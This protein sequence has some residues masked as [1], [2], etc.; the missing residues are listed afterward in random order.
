[1]R[2]RPSTILAPLLGLLLGLLATACGGGGAEVVDNTPP[3]PAPVVNVAPN[4]TAVGTTPVVEGAAVILLGVAVDADGDVLMTTWTVASQPAGAAAVIDGPAAG[5]TSVSGVL[6]PGTYEFR[7]E[8][9][10]GETTTDAIATVEVEAVVPAYRATVFAGDREAVPLVGV[11]RVTAADATSPPFAAT[12]G[13]TAYEGGWSGL[14]RARDATGAYVSD[15]FWVVNDRGPNYSIS[16]RVPPVPAM[17]TAFGAGAKYFPLPAY[18]QKLLRVRLNRSTGEATTLATTGIRSRSGAPTVGLPSSVTGM[19]TAETSWSNLDDKTSGLA[20]S[21]DGFDFEGVVEDRVAIAGVDKRVFWTCDEYGPAIQMLEADPAS[22][23]FGRVL[24]EYVPGATPNPGAGLFALPSILRQRRD[25]RGFEGLAVTGRHVWAMVQSHLK[26]SFGAAASRLHRFVRLDK[27]T[28]AVTIYGYDHVADPAALGTT[29]ASVKIGDMVAIGEREFLVIEHDGATY[30]HVYRV[31]VTDATTVLLDAE[32]GNYEK[33]LTPY[34]PV[35]KTL[36]A[37]LTATLADLRVPPKPEGLVVVDPQTIAMC[38]DN[39]YGFDADDTDVFPKPGD[40]ARNLIVTL[41]LDE[42]LFPTLEVVGDYNPGV[43]TNNCEIPSYDDQLE[44][45][46]ISCEGDASIQVFDLSEPTLPVFARRDAIGGGAVTSVAAHAARGYYLAP[47]RDGGPGGTDVL[48]VRR[49]SD[50]LLLRELDLGAQRDPDAVTISPNGRWAVVCNEAED[51]WAPGSIA[52]VDLGVGPFADPIA[53]ALAIVGANELSLAGLVPS[54]GAFSTRWVD[55]VYNAVPAGVTVTVGGL[56]IVLPAGTRATANAISVADQA[57]VTFTAGATV[58]V[59]KYRFD[60][61]DHAF[62]FPLSGSAQTL[63]PELA[64]F[65]P[66]GTQCFVTLQENNVVVALDFT[67]AAPAIRAANGVMGLGLVDVPDADVTNGGANAPAAGFKDLLQR[68]REPDGIAVAVLAGTLCFVTADEGDTFGATPTDS[69]S[70]RFRG[71]RTLSIFRASDGTLL[72]DTGNRLDAAVN[73]VGRWA[74]FVEPG[75]RPRRGGGEPENFTLVTWK[76]RTLAVVGLERANALALVDVS[77]PRGPT[78]LDLT[79]I[80]GLGAVART[81]PEGVK[82]FIF[83][84]RTFV[85]VGHEVSGTVG[86][87]EVR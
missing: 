38:F 34:T 10:D 84:G 39:D 31:R 9:G 15:E 23:D 2:V 6:P 63:E 22:A 64:A 83:E 29:H 59:G 3:P 62:L 86:I 78:V 25:N 8:A 37:D 81:A 24:R 85:I 58:V 52:I 18:Q 30:V 13:Y 60:S 57:D 68:E 77:D 66:D 56:P 79:G 51:F 69:S 67:L 27:H 75:S 11:V 5:I 53:A 20:P 55:R 14:G 74:A 35:E 28:G 4:V 65:S 47:V 54:T 19:T 43:G 33:G 40:E 80:G 70:S 87:F 12:L 82:A 36:V 61:P 45:G 76:D 26:S 73:A 7:F 48:Q 17:S 72:G 16:A 32:N 41:R 50:G 46:L 44:L 71:G 49:T 42:P 21:A 1:M